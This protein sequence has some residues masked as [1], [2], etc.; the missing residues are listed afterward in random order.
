MLLSII[1]FL[2]FIY[3]LYPKRTA[4][5]DLE[6]IL[7]YSKFNDSQAELSVQNGFLPDPRALSLQLTH[8]PNQ[9]WVQFAMDTKSMT[10]EEFQ[11][12]LIALPPPD[13]CAEQG[14]R[15]LTLAAF[16]TVVLQTFKVSFPESLV[17]PENLRQSICEMEELIGHD[18]HCDLVF[19]SITS[20]LLAD[21]HQPISINNVEYHGNIVIGADQAV[22]QQAGI[23]FRSIAMGLVESGPLMIKGV[24]Q[25][26]RG[27]VSDSRTIVQEGL[28]SVSDA[29]NALH[30]HFM[31]FAKE[32]DPVAWDV[33]A[34]ATAGHSGRKLGISGFQH[35]VVH[36]L[37]AL[38]SRSS[39]ES[40]VGKASLQACATL[41]QRHRRFI[42]AVAAFRP[43]LQEF[44]SSHAGDNALN[45]A[46]T[47]CLRSYH[48]FLLKH[49][50]TAKKV[51]NGTNQAYQ[52]NDGFRGTTGG[53]VNSSESPGDQAELE[54][55]K[56]ERE[57]PYR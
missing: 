45:K 54:L 4:L 16:L 2:V 41:H 20:I 52:S 42:N 11:E 50:N 22:Q 23:F 26:V 36:L 6:Q 19:I 31:V 1:L 49:A 38:F 44:H 17:G 43:T 39:Y 55:K 18:A 24:M 14:L 10:M 29:I 32:V 34:R 5:A 21:C 46:F 25:I 30:N 37:D 12:R 40:R 27:I 53:I 57:R 28:E 47:K 35:P 13:L 3:S 15:R 8:P 9:Q 51:L 56:A 48:Q 33:V 7:N